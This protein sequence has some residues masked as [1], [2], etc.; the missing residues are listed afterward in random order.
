MS[1]LLSMAS[2]S[3][4]SK[5]QPSGRGQRAE[6]AIAKSCSRKILCSPEAGDQFLCL[7]LWMHSLMLK[8]LKI[9]LKYKKFSIYSVLP[10]GNASISHLP[11]WSYFK[12]NS[13]IFQWETIYWINSEMNCWAIYASLA[14]DNC[15][16]TGR[17]FLE[18]YGPGRQ[19]LSKW[20]T[21][22]SLPPQALSGE[23]GVLDVSWKLPAWTCL[24]LPTWASE[25]F[26]VL[27]ELL[28]CCTQTEPS[29]LPLSAFDEF[30]FEAP[31]FSTFHLITVPFDLPFFQS[32]LISPYRSQDKV[33]NL[34]ARKLGFNK[35][36]AQSSMSTNNCRIRLPSLIWNWMQLTWIMKVMNPLR[37]SLH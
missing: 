8:V 37:A 28:L 27:W 25:V 11:Y 13:Y 36:S 34:A 12:H 1:S 2:V 26:T 19:I 17:W 5:T 20:P 16:L 18:A 35:S 6:E 29:C 33:Y 7:A 10:K 3:P 24:C 14:G 23:K 30:V 22:P 4:A 9:Q 21:F 31:S 32:F 15:T